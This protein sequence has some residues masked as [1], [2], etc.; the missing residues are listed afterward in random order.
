MTAE[1]QKGF[2]KRRPPAVCCD[3]VSK[4]R[5]LSETKTIPVTTIISKNLTIK[6][7]FAPRGKQMH[8]ISWQCKYNN[9][10]NNNMCVCVCV[11]VW[12]W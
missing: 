4:G 3:R 8:T 7:S 5:T 6:F 12:V 1:R 10:N 9:N 11:Y 2:G